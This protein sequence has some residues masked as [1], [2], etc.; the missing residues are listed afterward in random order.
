M[1]GNTEVMVL[2]TQTLLDAGGDIEAPGAVIGGGTPLA[3][4]GIRAVARRAPP[5]RA[6]HTP[7]PRRRQPPCTDRSTGRTR[8]S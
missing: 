8:P 5:R 2:D 7:P 3:D 6:Q 4:A 1:A